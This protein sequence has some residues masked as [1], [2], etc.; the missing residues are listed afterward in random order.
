ME[1]KGRKGPPTFP[2]GG[3]GAIHFSRGPERGGAENGW[4]FP[5][6]ELV[7]GPGLVQD[8]DEEAARSLEVERPGSMELLGRFHVEP[9]GLQSLV[10]LVDPLTTFLHETDVERAG[11]FNFGRLVEVVQSKN[12]LRFVDQHR[13]SVAAHLR[14]TAEPEIGLEEFPGPGDVG[15]GEI[16]VIQSH[17]RGAIAP[18]PRIST[19]SGPFSPGEW[20]ES[21]PGSARG[22]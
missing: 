17:E 13:E 16:Q 4:P 22:Y 19:K 2:G 9:V 6:L 15:D 11:V 7:F 18:V 12:E 8:L 14:D 10:H 3:K 20:L 5:L 21:L 1:V